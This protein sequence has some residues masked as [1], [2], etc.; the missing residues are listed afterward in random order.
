MRQENGRKNTPCNKKVVPWLGC[1]N[2]LRCSAG[3]EP[4]RKRLPVRRRNNHPAMKNHP[5]KGVRAELLDAH[6]RK[7]SREKIRAKN[8][9]G[10]N[11]GKMSFWREKKYNY[12][13]YMFVFHYLLRVKRC[14]SS[15]PS[16]NRMLLRW[17]MTLPRRSPTPNVSALF[18]V[19]G[20]EARVSH[21]CKR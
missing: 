19:L 5:W 12:T 8:W 10:K 1:V 11:G 15:S 2:T 16:T 17:L 18:V 6:A 20:G 7:K 9:R 3:D 13:V 14:F 21:A 4:L